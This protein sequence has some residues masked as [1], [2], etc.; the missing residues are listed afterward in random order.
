MTSNSEYAADLASLSALADRAAKAAL[1]A[2]ADA[3]RAAADA[4]S[5]AGD[6]ALYAHLAAARLAAF[7]DEVE[8]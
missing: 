5:L 4:A 3:D 2:S 7:S 8:K 6:A 1:A